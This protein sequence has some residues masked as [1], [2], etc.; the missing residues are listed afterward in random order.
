MEFQRSEKGKSI[1]SLVALKAL[2]SKNGQW[3]VFKT[4]E[5]ADLNV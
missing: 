4:L 3:P 2:K 5:V 1:D